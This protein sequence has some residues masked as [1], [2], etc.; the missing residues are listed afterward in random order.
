[1]RLRPAPN[2]TALSSSLL[3]CDYFSAVQW[4]YRVG[5]RARF[6]QRGFVE[7]GPTELPP[8]P[9]LLVHCAAGTPT[10]APRS[11]GV[12][13][14]IR[15]GRHLEGKED[16]LPRLLLLCGA[17]IDDDDTYEDVDPL[18][19]SGWD[20]ATQEEW[21]EFL[22]E[23]RLSQCDWWDV[24]RRQDTGFPPTHVDLNRD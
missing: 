21:A 16:E 9:G 14:T 7:E 8:C 10:R 15:P 1:M 2:N 6:P 18:D 19:P 3:H 20:E 24:R 11:C 23:S 4:G 5:W 22:Q 13:T 17:D 12:T